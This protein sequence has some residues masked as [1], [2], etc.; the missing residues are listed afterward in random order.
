LGELWYWWPLWVLAAIITFAVWA[1]M[2][3]PPEP[4]PYAVG[5]CLRQPTAKEK[6]KAERR[7]HFK[8]PG[9]VTHYAMAAR[10]TEPGVFAKITKVGE[11][12]A[13]CPV[14]TDA[15]YSDIGASSACARNLAAPHEGD[16]GGG[17]GC[18]ASGTVCKSSD[19][20]MVTRTVP[21]TV[22]SVARHPHRP[23]TWSTRSSRPPRASRA[24][25][26]ERRHSERRLPA[27][28]TST[29]T[30]T[31]RTRT[32]RVPTRLSCVWPSHS[33]NRRLRSPELWTTAPYAVGRLRSAYA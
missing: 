23:R 10:C 17:G 28:R 15:A 8:L 16:P 1:S 31:G 2:S 14:D 32:G 33:R 3:G 11:E 13:D 19:T 9:T 30:T 5:N 12:D 27:S 26:A 4:V 22:K 24:A 6:E 21:F 25:R 7:P 29:S 20:P 18:C